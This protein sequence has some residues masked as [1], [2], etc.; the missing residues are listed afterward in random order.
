VASVVERPVGIDTPDEPVERVAA[1]HTT[2]VGSRG[3][4]EGETTT[5]PASEPAAF[6]DAEPTEVIEPE[7][8]TPAPHP[9]IDTATA[10][11]DELL[12]H[13]VAHVAPL[14][15]PTRD[16]REPAQPEPT[17]E[18][19]AA[20]MGPDR[21]EVQR[22]MDA[23]RPALEE[24]AAGGHGLTQV[25]LTVTPSG[26]ARAVRISGPFAGSP[27]GSCMARTARSARFA[28]HESDDDVTVRYP[29]RF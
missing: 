24:C 10:S 27:E 20:P 18:E 5:T 15:L 28:E 12:E 14:E 6:A 11:M 8:T 22:V 23:L 29:Y 21:A 26:R 9:A 3:A 4:S 13:A 1:H 17:V 25:R 19:S 7:V 16:D 2:S